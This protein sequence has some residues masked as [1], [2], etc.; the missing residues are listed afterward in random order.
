MTTPLIAN[1]NDPQY[2]NQSATDVLALQIII[3]GVPADPDEQAVNVTMTN[4]STSAVIFS[5]AADRVANQTGEYNLTLLVSDTAIVGN[6]TVQWAYSINGSAVTYDTYITVGPY[7]PTYASLVPAMRAIVEQVWMR[8]ADEFDSPA[9]GP[10]LQT[11]YQSRFNRGRIAELLKIACGRLN[12]QS[13]PYMT[14]TIDGQQGA[15]FPVAQWGPLLEQAC[16]VET[17]K[18]LRRSYLE[19]PDFQG[20]GITRVDRQSYFDRWGEVLKEEQQSLKDQ[21]DVFKIAQMRLGQPRV[22]VAG[23]VFGRYSPTRYSAGMAAA[24]GYFLWSAG[25]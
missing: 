10:N 5:R 25:Y 3:G 1:I 11:Y 6:Y 9:G 19:Q 7:S 4:Q 22:L 21:L 23:G 8:F 18:H 15:S 2:I 17:I 20:G 14:Y 24:R 16:Y 13:Q 12:T